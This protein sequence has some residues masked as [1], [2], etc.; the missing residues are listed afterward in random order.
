MP[1][2][3]KI[4]WLIDNDV[5]ASKSEEADYLEETQPS[6]VIHFKNVPKFTSKVGGHLALSG[7]SFSMIF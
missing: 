7:L 5:V 3:G 4:M 1:P 6:H 2:S